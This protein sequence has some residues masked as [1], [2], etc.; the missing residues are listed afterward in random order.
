MAEKK[1]LKGFGPTKSGAAMSGFKTLGK[2]L[3]KQGIRPVGGNVHGTSG[4]GPAA[5][6]DVKL[7]PIGGKSVA[8]V[9]K[10][11]GPTTMPKVTHSATLK[12]VSGMSKKGL[13]SKDV[14]EQP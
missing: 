5:S 13:A 7:T 2:M 6:G 14:S 8:C 12:S 4:G 9:S 11:K 1:T 10:G 3:S